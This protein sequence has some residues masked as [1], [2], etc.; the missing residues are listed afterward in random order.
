[1][2]TVHIAPMHGRS[3][4][5]IW[6][7]SSLCHL[8]G[9]STRCYI[10]RTLEVTAVEHDT[11]NLSLWTLRMQ[12]TS[13]AIAVILGLAEMRAGPLATHVF[14]RYSLELTAV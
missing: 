7:S 10:Q 11:Q 3:Q 13:G 9:L 4:P 14:S 12:T 5:A 8:G 2:E 1:M 6:A